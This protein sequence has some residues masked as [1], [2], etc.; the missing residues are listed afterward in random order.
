MKK[1]FMLALSVL[2]SVSLTIAGVPQVFAA[3]PKI[4]L[5]Y[6]DY[7]APGYD[8]LNYT[9]HFIKRIAEET[10]GRVEI[11]LYP[12]E[13]LVKAMQQYEAI[14]QGT[15]DMCNITPAYFSG[16]IPLLMLTSESTY[17]EP[18]DSVVIVSRTAGD[19]SPILAKDGIKFMGWSTEQ[20][21]M[22]T[23]GPK[24]FKTFDDYKGMKIRAPGTSGKIIAKWGGTGVSIPAPDL[25][26]A[27]SNKVV[28]GAFLSLGTVEG[29][30]LWEICP[31]ITVTN[32]G[33]T[34]QL[35][36]MNMKKWESLPP[37]IKKA[38]EK[39]NREMVSWAHQH[40]VKYDAETRKTLKAK[41]KIYHTRTPEERAVFV[42][43]AQGLYWKPLIQKHGDTAQK[44]WDRILV[45]AKECE[46]A[47]A[48][49]KTPKYFE[50]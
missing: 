2:I 15:I 8:Q 4:T 5:T 30:R 45:V 14:M 21:P 27:I 11:K 37:D 46:A 44:M 25:Y 34:P 48:K 36:A 39:V 32:E 35:A 3:A 16:K 12:S 23:V 33:G 43:G 26:M 31:A 6:A 41:F 24:V 13:Q 28:D 49:G 29:T 50:D 47:R 42:V 40:A 9:N 20:P 38:F 18:G 10:K 19:I 7:A 22:C 17:W 1:A